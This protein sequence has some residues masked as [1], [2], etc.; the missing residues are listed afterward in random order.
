VARK[1]ITDAGY[2]DYFIHRVG[3]GLGLDVHEEPYMVGG[4][5]TPLRAGM[6]F[7]DEPGIY[8]PGE[9]GVRLEDDMHVA[10]AGARWFTPQSPSIEQP[11]G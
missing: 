5:R 9:F 11:F 4:N 10:E 8:L 6:V 7:S 1:V 2:G 3:H